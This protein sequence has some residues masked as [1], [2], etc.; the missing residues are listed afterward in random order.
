MASETPSSG[1]I[2]AGAVA[3]GAAAAAVGALSSHLSNLSGAS[4]MGDAKLSAA[5]L[6]RATF[7]ATDASVAALS[8]QGTEAWFQTQAN[9][10]PTAGGGPGYWAATPN[11]HLNFVMRRTNDFLVAYQQALAAAQAATPPGGTPAKVNKRQVTSQQFQESFWARAVTGDDQLRA[12]MALAL[13]EI[14]VVSFSG[15]TIT[16]R[17]AASWYDMLS[18]HAFGNYF[19][20]MKAVTLHPAMGIYLNIIGNMQADN[21]PTRHPDENYGREIMQLMSIGLVKLN[22]DGSQQLD[23]NGAPVAAYS[24]NDIAGLATTFTGWGWYNAKPSAATFAKQ[25]GDGSDTASSDV[26]PLIAYPAYHSQLAKTFLGTTIPAYTGA[27]PTT[28]AGAAALAAYQ[29]QGLDT[30]IRTV[31]NHPNVGPFLALRLI[32]RFV[33]SN[34]SPAYINRVATVFNG[35]AGGTRGDLFATLQAV[36]TD[37]EAL[38]QTPTSS[39]TAGKLREP[40]V[41]MAHFLRA[42]GAQSTAAATTPSGNWTPYEDFSAPTALAQAPLSAPSVFNFWAF[43]FTPNG[44]AIAQAGKVA[45]EF[46][47]VDVLTVAGYANT[48]TQVVQAKGWPG[49]DVVT[50]YAGEIAALTPANATAADND[51]ALIDRLNLLYFGGQMSPTLSARLTRVISSTGADV[52]A[53]TAAQRAQIR[54]DKT[55]NALLIVTTSPEYLVQ[56]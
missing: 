27:Q 48:M 42:T 10:A 7:G 13:S 46:Q 11:F 6:N 22:N 16:A 49:G 47:A 1:K 14:M 41:R 39:P 5:F 51:Q 31:A 4:V 21:D 15:T 29:A 35:A 40:V 19:D 17:I 18:A 30:A 8:S 44:S 43:D 54:L 2:V 12:R 53:P 9:A 26:Q 52:K 36:L 56:A 23:A 38:S 37:T 33:T 55:R 32:Q 28:A 3:V 50:T 25:P 45:P 24:H 20:L 34:P